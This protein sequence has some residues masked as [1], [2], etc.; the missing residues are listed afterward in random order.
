MKIGISFLIGMLIFTE[1]FAM[2]STYSVVPAAQLKYSSQF[3]LQQIL[4]KKNIVLIPDLP[5]P[6]NLFESTTPLKAFQDAIE[7]QWGFRPKEFTS[8]YVLNRNEIY[9]LDNAKYYHSQHRCIDDTLAHELTH[10]VQFKYQHADLND[11]FLESEAIDIQTWF[12]EK[13]CK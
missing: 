5:L 6:K 1:L 8:A 12:R 13:F 11:E 10:Y 9:L 4:D 7:P 2:T 3:I